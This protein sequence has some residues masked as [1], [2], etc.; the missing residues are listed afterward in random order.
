MLVWTLKCTDKMSSPFP[1]LAFPNYD[2]RFK[3]NG[4]KIS[5]FDELRKKWLVCT[6]EEWVRQNLVKYLINELN[7]PASLIALEK[8]LSIA[9]REYRFD[10][11][12]YNREFK[13]LLIIECKAPEIKLQ[14]KVFDQIWEYNHKINAPYFLVTN[15]LGFIMG[16]VSQQKGV[17]YFSKPVDFDELLSL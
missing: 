13:P 2:F 1:Q 8:G 6:P 15:G 5:V 12:V 17:E 10:A 11:L 3:K 16:K 7:Y 14:Q 9:G 4:D